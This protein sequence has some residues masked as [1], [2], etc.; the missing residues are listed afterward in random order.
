MHVY[1]LLIFKILYHIVAEED[2][3]SIRY[4]LQATQEPPQKW[5]ARFHRAIVVM[6]PFHNKRS[7]KKNCIFA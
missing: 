1:A 2:E 7:K 3:M 4:L 5:G 6:K